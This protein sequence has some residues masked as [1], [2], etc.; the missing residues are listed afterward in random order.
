[1]RDR[2]C[3]RRGRDRGSGGRR[4]ARDARASGHRRRRRVG[5][6]H[7]GAGAGAGSVGLAPPPEPR[8]GRGHPC[9]PLRGEVPRLR[10]R[11]HRR[12]RRPAPRRVG[13]HRARRRATT[14]ARSCWASGTSSAT[15]RPPRNRFGNGVSNF[16][17]SLFAGRTLQ[18]TQCGLRRYPVRRDARSRRPRLGLRLRGGGRLAGARGGAPARG[19]ARSRSIYPP[20]DHPGSHFRRVVDPTR[21]VAT[22]VRTVVELRR[23]GS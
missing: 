17:L 7:G 20:V 9:G 11:A 23:G 5:R 4:P 8:Q 6:R 16:F 1:M 19:G 21:I 2:A 18:D 13:A 14:R 12:R 3:A 15:A 22:V 10:G